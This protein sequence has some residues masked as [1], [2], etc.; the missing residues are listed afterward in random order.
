MGKLNFIPF[1][2]T[3]PLLLNGCNPKA[4][5]KLWL[6]CGG[7]ILWRR[8][9]PTYRAG[10]MHP[11]SERALLSTIC[12]VHAVIQRSHSHRGCPVNQSTQSSL[13]HRWSIPV[14]QSAALE[15]ILARG[16]IHI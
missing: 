9:F 5:L 1:D 15:E 10:V 2:V 13:K 3:L 8:Y 11:G 14:S 12:L 7:C 4:Q 16:M 6:C